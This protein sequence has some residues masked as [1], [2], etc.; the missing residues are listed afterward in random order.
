MAKVPVD[1]SMLFAEL[2]EQAYNKALSGGVDPKNIAKVNVITKK[3]DTEMQV[4][5]IIEALEEISQVVN[6]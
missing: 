4:L 6:R 1:E 5:V 3:S 2:K